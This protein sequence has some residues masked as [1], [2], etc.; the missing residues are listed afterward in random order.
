MDKVRTHYHK[1]YLLHLAM[2]SIKPYIYVGHPGQE[3]CQKIQNC[4]IKWQTHSNTYGLVTSLIYV[5]QQSVKTFGLSRQKVSFF[6][7]IPFLGNVIANQKGV[8]QFRFRIKVHK[9]LENSCATSSNP[10]SILFKRHSR[11][12]SLQ[13]LSDLS[14]EWIEFDFSVDSSIVTLTVP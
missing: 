2:V 5:G 6:I 13:R 1:L 12:F 10:H 14:N 3:F 11:M 8:W 9:I 7:G 4:C